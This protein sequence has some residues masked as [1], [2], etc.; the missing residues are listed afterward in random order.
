M[1]ECHVMAKRVV[2]MAPEAPAPGEQPGFPR[3]LSRRPGTIVARFP[4][5]ALIAD[6]G[7]GIGAAND[8]ASDLAAALQSFAQAVESERAFLSAP[9]DFND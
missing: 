2:P 9:A 8:R 6:A 4:G 1:N 3:G 5:P 7:G